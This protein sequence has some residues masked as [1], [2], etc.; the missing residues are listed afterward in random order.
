MYTSGST[1]TPKGIVVP[2]RG[3]I[4]L[5]RN[6]DYVEISP[7]DRIAQIANSAFDAATFEI[8]GALLN[9]ASISIVDRE[10]SLNPAK[11][12]ERIKRD[13]ITALFLTTAL[14]NQMARER[15]GIF[16]GLR[17][18]LFGGEAVDP[19]WPRRVLES[20]APEHLLHVY[21][22]TETTT[23]ATWEGIGSIESEATTIPIGQPIANTQ[24]YVLDGHLQPVP[25]GVRGE[26]YLAGEGVARGYLCRGAQTAERFVANPYGEGGERMY[27]TGDV[28]RRNGEGRIEFVGR[29]DEQV[30]I[31][32]FR[33]EL[34]EI[35]TALREMAGVAQVVVIAREDEPG[36][37]RLIGY[38]TGE[39]LDAEALRA[40]LHAALPEYMTPSAIVVLDELPLN[41]NGKVDRKALPSP[42]YVQKGWR[43]P[44]TPQ[45]EI[46]CSLFAETLGVDRV[47]LDDNFFELGGHSLLAM[48]LVSRLRRMGLGLEINVQDLFEA[49]TVGDLAPRLV[50][51]ERGYRPVEPMARPA[52]IPLS[53]AQRRLWFLGKLEGPSATY[54]IPFA[55]RLKGRVSASALEAALRDVIERH[56]SLRTIFPETLGTP[57]QQVLGV[58]ECGFRLERLTASE[59]DLQRQAGEI[60]ARGFDVG[61]EIPFRAFLHDGGADNHLLLIVLHHIAGDG[62]SLG[63]LSRDL[64]HAYA[65]RRAGRKPVWTALPVQY[66]DYTLWQQQLLGDESDPE[67][68]ISR[69]LRYWK[70][71]LDGLPEELELPKDRPR[72]P[73]SSYRGGS[74][75]MW[76]EPALHERLLALARAHH[77][78]LFMVMQSAIAA[79]LTRLGAGTDIPLG[80]PIAGRTD[81]KLEQLVGFFVNTLVLRTDTSGDPTFEELLGRVRRADLQAYAHQDLPFER[82]VDELKPERSLARHP[83]FQVML[84][85]QSETAPA[86][87]LAGVQVEPLSLSG[88]PAKFDLI[89]GFRERRAADGA[90]AGMEGGLRYSVDLFDAETQQAFARRL[91]RLLESIAADPRQRIGD[92]S[93]LTDDERERALRGWN[94]TEL[95]LTGATLPDLFE[96]RVQASPH[97][98]ALWCGGRTLSYAELNERANRVA[99]YLLSRGVGPESLVGISLPRSEEMMVGILGALKAGAAYLPIDLEYPAERRAFIVEDAR[100]ALILDGADEMRRA[101][102]SQPAGNP[103]RTTLRQSHPAYVI[104]TSGSTGVPKGVTITH[105]NAAAFLDWAQ[106]IF[107][108]GD[109]AGTIAATSICF[110]LSIFEMFATLRAGGCVLLVQNAM[111]SGEAD[112]RA[113]LINTVPS[114]AAELLRTGQM[115]RVRVANIAGEPLPRTLVDALYAFGIE[116][117]YNLYGPTEDTTYSTF[118]LVP[119]DPRA[120][121]T[122]GKPV[123][124]SQAYVL[125]EKLQPVPEGVVGELYLAGAG[126]AR[127]YFRRGALTA[128]R[129][130][131]SPWG[132]A[133]SRMYRTGDLVR[134]RGDGDLEYLGRADEQIKLRGYRIELGEIEAALRREPGVA[135]A[136][137]AL[138]DGRLV[139]YVVGSGDGERLRRSLRERLPEY[140][141]PAAVVWLESLPLNRSG[142]V[143]RRA[144]PS[145]SYLAK[146]FRAPATPRQEILCRLF[147]ETLGVVRVGLDDNFFELG[148]DSI[149]SIQLVSRAR[150][151]G[152]VITPRDVFQH[153]TVE[154]LAAVAEVADEGVARDVGEAAG[155]M[156]PTPIMRW[157]ADRG[158]LSDGFSQSVCLQVPP[159]LGMER[160]REAV[161][162]VVDHHDA[163]RMR[164]AGDWNGADWSIEIA[165]QGAI[166]GRE[167]VRRVEAGA[168]RRAVLEREV[169]DARRRLS[170]AAGVMLQV[171]WLDAGSERPGWL[172]VTAHHLVIDGVSWR[173]LL[174]DLRRA[175]EGVALDGKGTSFRRWHE[176]LRAGAAAR[177]GELALW[178]SMLDGADELIAG[179]LDRRR[180]RMRTAGVLRLNL[181]ASAT[182]ALLTEVPALFRGTI[183]DVLLAAL[184]L[185]IGR[186]KRESGGWNGSV[187]VDL[188]GHGREEIFRGVDLSRTVGWFTTLHP[189]RLETEGIDLDAA[190]AGQSALGSAVKR[191]KESL[192]RVPDGGLGYGL[193][194]H[195]DGSM[196]RGEP[197]IGFNYMGRFRTGASGGGDWEAAADS[198][199]L[200]GGVDPEMPLIHPLELS[201]IAVERADG[202]HLRAH[203][204]WAPALVGEADVRRIALGWFEALE[205]LAEY[206][207]RPNVGGLTPS[208]L[209][210]VDLSQEEIEDFEEWYAKKA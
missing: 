85:F 146:P 180:D 137:V 166:S 59:G 64:A 96:A 188:E 130:V 43:A 97:A 206:A 120:M 140:M 31:R 198:G 100:P 124:S 117:V 112:G 202:T 163:I 187:V 91:L 98:S 207:R 169:E 150:K 199:M 118:T 26:L 196:L 113:T 182:E 40:A 15:S 101:I 80:S 53:F 22:P 70:E 93:I 160:L 153:Q 24:C 171:V 51:A 151:A 75:P 197:K 170:P 87:A 55:L 52:E 102:E 127:G 61:A 5:V 50:A 104:Y 60:A 69:Q 42:E 81:S 119:R 71:A 161:Q 18:V 35:E 193:L 63:P 77:A 20:G 122:I 145:P 49:P 65:A 135:H 156:P 129:F 82:L 116:R 139:A 45:E 72:P 67:S 39:Q 178:Q 79:L 173:I 25:L 201:A 176:L 152:L 13:G 115:P 142:K 88:E 141:V 144:L 4:R 181:P 200:V 154:A 11:L 8:W 103:V 106:T 125:D 203:W 134:R 167:L 56:E 159:S 157:A 121:V 186:W 10:T 23:F 3:V 175:W 27:R 184:Y 190:W 189:V 177:A 148:G 185:S 164:V 192:R 21:G 46:L 147:G 165:P 17:Y 1:G 7:M 29:T 107:T 78:S 168:D 86:I 83:L 41:T 89:I 44:R 138:R 143:D 133:G 132:G 28:V 172:L 155:P 111:H 6:T 12:E 136:A 92:L 109:L 105:A 126:L 38:V 19:Q 48:R 174:P 179:D 9:G 74:V 14:F 37:K 32:G 99:H 95:E 191:V 58:S 195:A 57:R 110:D 33:V 73:L 54:N 131:A 208:D 162:R 36:E 30:K 183:N 149:V 128:Q 204:T 158:I 205:K 47:G 194:R 66:A 2:Q 114:A 90:A 209:P 16:A 94:Q 68:A 62:W 84:T 34:G 123:G 210:L 76:I 108:P